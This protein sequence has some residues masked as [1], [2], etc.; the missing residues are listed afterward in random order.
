MASD[1][2]ERT[3]IK[4]V[5]A[6]SNVAKMVQNFKNML[7]NVTNMVA[8]EGPV[9]TT[10]IKFK[11]GSN[12]PIVFDSSST[13]P[14][15]NLIASL[16]F[17][18]VGAG[19]ANDF[20]LTI[21]YDPFN[22]GQETADVVEVLDE[23]VAKAMSMGGGDFDND[24][25]FLTGKIQYGYNSL[26]DN[27]LVS[28]EYKFF[29]TNAETKVKFNSGISTYTF[30]GTSM[31][32]A[33]CDNNC[34][35]SK[36]EDWKLMDIIEWT[37]YYWYGDKSNKPKHTGDGTPTDNIYKYKIDIPDEV[38][39]NGKQHV[40]VEAKSGMTPW[41]Y[42]QEL[43]DL[44]PLTIAEEQSKLYD[45]LEMLSYAQ[46]PRYVMYLDDS[47]KTIHVTHVVPSV[48]TDEKGKTTRVAE[49]SLDDL[50]MDYE[51]SWGKQDTNI[52]IDWSP[53][54]DTS[55]YLI[56]KARALRESRNGEISSRIAAA[57]DEGN[58][59][60]AKSLRQKLV[61]VNDDLN[62][63]FDAQ[64]TIVGIPSDIPLGA[65]VRIVPRI[66]ETISRTAG[67]YMITGASD[68]IS[69]N[70]TYTTTL[71]LFR[72]SGIGEERYKLPATPEDKANTASKTSNETK[73]ISYN[74]SGGSFSGRQ[75]KWSEAGGAGG[76]KIR[77]MIYGNCR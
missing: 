1:Y 22:M 29:I 69:S 9:Y 49:K 62:E 60:L 42:C 38:Y 41:Q 11:I 43:L 68:S 37:L 57:E 54:V 10:W 32:S 13:N 35:F 61:T 3:N 77:S 8:T 15:K 50:N 14:K 67:V 7:N 34:D 72:V 71:D 24:R 17:N 39:N 74:G 27:S 48:V 30:E 20:T 53:Q 26:S 2:I 12:N 4:S 16:D 28:P 40:N 44:Y 25:N 5:A 33:D 36:I 6:T 65:E 59:E 21:Q 66:L 73:T 75:G 51:F 46:R 63:M 64:L 56:R 31:L 58:E 47:T 19:V 70:G 55:L 45:N 52:I 76:R 18:K 23:Y